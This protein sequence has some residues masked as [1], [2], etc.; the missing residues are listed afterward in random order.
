[1]AALL[2]FAFNDLVR[3]FTKLSETEVYPLTT[4]TE[5]PDA[6]YSSL[7][8]EV[9]ALDEVQ[10]QAS[11]RVSGYHYCPHD[12]NYR[13]SVV[14]YAIPP[15]Y[16]R[17]EGQPPSQTV[18]LPADAGV[19]STEFKLPLQSSL[20]FYPF[21]TSTLTLGLDLR[22][23]TPDGMMPLPL[24]NY[25]A[26]AQLFVSIQEQMPRVFMESPTVLDPAA[27]QS[28]K[29]AFDYLFVDRLAFTRPLYLRVLVVLMVL[30]I[31][32]AATYAVFLRPFSDLIINAGALV[33]GVW[34]VRSL[35]I[36]NLPPDVTAVDTA[37]VAVI[38]FLLTT[39]TARGL[40]YL[41]ARSGLHLP[42]LRR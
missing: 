10:R 41:H 9:I 14:F 27:V 21:D 32:T 17:I 4:P 13:E 3:Y 16:R 35:L 29:V 24:T 36:G 20:A 5:N 39:I 15:T 31:A 28:R 2:P 18:N 26:A 33:L 42:G 19:V 7:H 40:R 8:V 22:R 12:C 30:L 25:N 37:L 11:L 6:A 1:M 38:F 23:T 34:G